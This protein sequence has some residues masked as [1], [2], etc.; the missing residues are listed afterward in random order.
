M[1]EKKKVFSEEFDF[2]FQ[3]LA[4]QEENKTPAA[5]KSNGKLVR[6]EERSLIEDEM[7]DKFDE[8][9]DFEAISGK[10]GEILILI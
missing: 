2:D 3:D 5:A 7:N 4:G 1:Q 10:K 8:D 9:L 6:I